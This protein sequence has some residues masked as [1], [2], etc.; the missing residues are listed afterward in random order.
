MGPYSR[1]K[2]LRQVGHQLVRRYFEL[3]PLSTQVAW[4]DL[5]LGDIDTVEAAIEASDGHRCD[6]DFQL[7]HEM[8]TEGGSVLLVQEVRE[9]H[10]LWAP[11][12]DEMAND[13]ERAMLCFLEDRELFATVSSFAEMDRFSEGR[14]SPWP[15][16]TR[17]KPAK[18]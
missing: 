6:G 3:R 9:S 12:L 8:A 17:L 13:Y 14:W 16:G 11:K 2:V 7:I 4:D 10:G 18:D 5:R 15:V 1:R